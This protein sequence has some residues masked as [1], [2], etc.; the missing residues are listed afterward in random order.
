MTDTRHTITDL[1]AACECAV[2]VE[3]NTHRNYYMSA[4]EWLAELD[5]R[6]CPPDIDPARRKRM[7]ETNSVVEVQAYPKT[8]IGFIR[9]FHFDVADA[10]HLA[11]TQAQGY[12]K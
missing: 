4:E 5:Q 3:V 11:T 2:T 9:V 6:E 10:I 12:G 8:P 7:I 1:Y